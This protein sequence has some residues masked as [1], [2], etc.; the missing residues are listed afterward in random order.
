MRISGFL[1]LL[2]SV[3]LV[4]FG[5][6]LRYGGAILGEGNASAAPTATIDASASDTM[7]ASFGNCDGPQRVNCVVDGDTFWFAGDKIRILDI[8]TPEISSPQCDREY[9]LGMQ[10]TQRLTQ[11]LNEGPFS[12][13]SDGRDTDRYGRLL[14]RVTRGGQSLGQVL[15]TEGLAEEWKGYKGE[16]C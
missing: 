6:T 4:G 3:V 16:W 1:V 15:V 8:N 7:S 14:R 11:L 12:L 2:L 5:V 9:R 13:E 10:A